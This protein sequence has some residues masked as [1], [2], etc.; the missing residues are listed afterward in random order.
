[1][2]KSKRRQDGPGTVILKQLQ[3][4]TSEVVRDEHVAAE[5]E[6][7]KHMKTCAQT[8]AE[9]IWK[10]HRRLMMGSTLKKVKK[11]KVDFYHSLLPSWKFGSK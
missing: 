11:K 3:L 2:K 10:A 1:M 7:K 8:I 4:K 6:K 5:Q 9:C